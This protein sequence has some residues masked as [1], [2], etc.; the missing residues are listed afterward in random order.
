MKKL[1]KITLDNGLNIFLYLDKRRHTTFFQL[2]N[3]FG[4][5]TKDFIV[6]N[7]EYHLPDGVAHILEHYVVEENEMGN[8]LE[9]LGK[10]QMHT[11]AATYRNMTNYYFEAVDNVLLGIETIL[12]GVYNVNF[13]E[14]KLLK[15]KEPIYQEIRGKLTDKFYHAEIKCMENLFKK[16][17][18]RSIGGDLSDIEKVTLNDL[19]VCY[20]A[21]YK[22]SNQYIIIAGNF[23]KEEVVKFLRDFYKNLKVEESTVKFMD[24]KEDKEVNKKEGVVYFPTAEEFVEI[25]YKID[26]KELS[27]KEMLDLDFYLNVFLKEVFGTTS[28]LYQK[29]VKEKIIT[30]NIYYSYSQCNSFILI[31]VSAYTSKDKVFLEKVNGY[32]DKVVLDEEFFE[33]EKRQSIMRIILRNE[34]IHNM[35]IPFIDNLVNFNYPYLDSVLDIKKDTFD[36]YSKTIK[37]LDLSNYTTI[38][39]KEKRK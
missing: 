26:V 7:K 13:S 34:E 35:I 33:I 37:G 23:D 1:E 19:K 31:K 8:F 21:F 6:N 15:I 27:P 14:E 11:N 3:L 9:I 32:L 22:P 5:E 12:K 16:I 20:D 24:Y 39:I 38:F 10:K 2:V 30:G 28:K 25:T 18:F 29:L 36:N 17:K 4:G